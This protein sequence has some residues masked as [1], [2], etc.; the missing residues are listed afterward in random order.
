M[1]NE[2]R[3]KYGV[4]MKKFLFLLFILMFAGKAQACSHHDHGEIHIDRVERSSYRANFIFDSLSPWNSYTLK[5]AR[6]HGKNSWEITLA[7][8]TAQGDLPLTITIDITDGRK[9][10]L[11]LSA[12]KQLASAQNDVN[13]DS[14]LQS[15]LRQ[16]FES[17]GLEN[18]D[19]GLFEGH[20][21]IAL[22]SGKHKRPWSL[23]MVTYRGGYK[24]TIGIVLNQ[25]GRP[26]TEIDG[27]LVIG[28]LKAIIESIRPL[29]QKA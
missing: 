24:Y 6:E 13:L 27:W 11:F 18:V 14:L 23:G 12:A 25:P 10:P 1:A 22:S 7:R 5:S 17:V 2:I 26:E 29:Y 8:D 21:F 15:E 3:E 19:H 9:Q 28:Q 4:F 20:R 16:P